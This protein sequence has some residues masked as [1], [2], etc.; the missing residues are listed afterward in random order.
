MFA[1]YLPP[2]PCKPFTYNPQYKMWF[3]SN[4]EPV[5]KGSDWGIWR[6]VKKF[7]GITPSLQK[8]GLANC[9]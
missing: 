9:R 4:Y 1:G 6:R 5:I 8:E 7:R 2:H 3:M